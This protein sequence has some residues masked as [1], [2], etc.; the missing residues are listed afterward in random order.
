MERENI[1]GRREGIALKK[2]NRG[3]GGGIIRFESGHR[4]NYNRCG[5]LMG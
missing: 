2:K 4:Q 3:A 1:G 5:F